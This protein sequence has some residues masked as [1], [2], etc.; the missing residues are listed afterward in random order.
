MNKSLKTGIAV[1]VALAVTAL[2]FIY[3]NPLAFFGESGSIGQSGQ[4]VV[5][6]ETIGTGEEARPG[7]I[8]QDG[9]VFDTSSGEE[10][11]RFMIGAGLM[12]QGWEQG[13]PGMRQ[14][15]KRL[16]IIPP[17]MAYGE[18]GRGPIPPNATLIFEVELVKVERPQ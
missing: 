2:F 9:T 13:L 1:V 14:G 16:L 6:D 17:E 3:S 5:Q 10:P 12:I 15:G 4:L 18:Q 11:P 8:L 7:D